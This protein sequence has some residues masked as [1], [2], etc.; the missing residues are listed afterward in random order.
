MAPHRP[1]PEKELRMML[2]S[3]EHKNNE[4]SQ[5]AVCSVEFKGHKISVIT[6]ANKSWAVI[7]ISGNGTF[8]KSWGV[9][10]K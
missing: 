1:D 3:G 8:S 6:H 2:D 7:S 9:F 5:H 10:S 4:K